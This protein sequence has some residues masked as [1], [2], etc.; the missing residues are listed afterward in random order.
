MTVGSVGLHAF[1]TRKGDHG[2]LTTR[3]CSVA[4]KDIIPFRSGL[5]IVSSDVIHNAALQRDVVNVL[6]HLGPGGVIIIDSSPRI[7][8]PSC[9]N[10]SVSHV[11]R[12]VTFGT[13]ITLLISGKVRSILL[14]TCGGT[15]QRRIVPYSTAMGYIGRVCTSFASRRVSTGVIRLLAPMKAHTG[16][17]VI[18]RALRKLRTTYPSRPNS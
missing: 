4:C 3:I 6:S 2:S 18:C 12:F 17:R 10:V 9:C 13:T 7:H 16:I 14:S 8:C 15:G 11:D 5:I 1:V